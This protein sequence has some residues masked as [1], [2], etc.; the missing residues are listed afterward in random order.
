MTLR[1]SG[2]TL[3]LLAVVAVLA[4]VAWRIYVSFEAIGEFERGLRIG[5][6]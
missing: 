2:R 4:V 3:F 5:V 6:D 1:T